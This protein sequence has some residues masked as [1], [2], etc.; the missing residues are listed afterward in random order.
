MSLEGRR[1]GGKQ[2]GDGDGN[3]TVP[4]QA[5]VDV[6][7]MF[8]FKVLVSRLSNASYAVRHGVYSF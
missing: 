6:S 8:G 2:E 4:F 3:E 1:G 7:E 5:E